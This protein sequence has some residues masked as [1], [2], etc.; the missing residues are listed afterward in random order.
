MEWS[1]DE[2]GTGKELQYSHMIIVLGSLK[3]IALHGQNHPYFYLR[4]R[5]AGQISSIAAYVH[6]GS[7]TTNGLDFGS[8]PSQP[9]F[10]SMLPVHIRLPERE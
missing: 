2:T 7:R 8:T 6:T 1:L 9:V 10:V 3:V 5:A 4:R